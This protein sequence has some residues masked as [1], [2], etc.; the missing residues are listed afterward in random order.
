MMPRAGVIA[1]G[2]D[3]ADLRLVSRWC[4][5]GELPV[6]A[7]LRDRGAAGVLTTP[8]GL[9]DDAVWASFST[10]LS[11]GRHGRYHH[12]Q[13]PPGSYAAGPF[14]EAHGE[15]FWDVLGRAGRR[16]AALD[17]PKCRLS[18]GP[19]GLQVSDWLVHGRDG[20]T[21]SFPPEV[22]A[23]LLASFGDDT[24]DRAPGH[25]C[26]MEAIP[27]ARQPELLERLLD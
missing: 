2:L 16:V 7:S 20:A 6:L 22:A 24:T 11:P 21:A 23:D 8:P 18:R 14:R 9:G 17:I 25:L 12:R 13:V 1:I 4:D 26:T 10:G 3:S 5:A 15:L 27:V 19:Y